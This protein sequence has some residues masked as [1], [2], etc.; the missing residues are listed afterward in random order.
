MTG[1][2]GQ[3]PGSGLPLFS[4]MTVWKKAIFYNDLQLNN[5]L[6]VHI[7]LICLYKF[8]TFSIEHK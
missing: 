7:I 5:K 1:T 6:I 3:A 4:P 8:K 2:S